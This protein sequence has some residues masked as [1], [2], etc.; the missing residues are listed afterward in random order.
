MQTH[1]C[2]PVRAPHRRRFAV[3]TTTVALLLPALLAASAAPVAAA[4]PRTDPSAPTT[5]TTAAPAPV[6]SRSA[7]GGP[8][9]AETGIVAAPGAP[10][11]PAVSAAAWVLADADTGEILA[12]K[13]PHAKY[14]PASTLKT[15]LAVTMAPRLDP[16]STYTADFEDTAQEGTRVGMVKDQTYKIDDLWYALLLRSGND[17]ATGI[18]KAGGGTLERGVAMMAAEAQRLQALDTTVVNPS[19][20]D[21]DGQFSSAYDLGLWGRALLARRDLRN[22]VK[23]IKH[24]FPGNKTKTA[25]KANSK[26]FQIYTENRLL[27]RGFP[28]AIGVKTGYTTKAQNTLIAAAERDGRTIIA[29][30]LSTPFGRITD[31]AGRLLEYGFANAGRVAPVGELVDPISSSVITDQDGGFVASPANQGPA[32]ARPASAAEE[33]DLVAADETTTLRWSA[34]AGGTLLGVLLLLAMVRTLA[35]RRRYARYGAYR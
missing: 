3:G 25:T 30:L 15:L 17:A 33:I 23:T 22:Y 7:I 26:S 1:T 28:G 5:S 16:N 4:D 2:L 9:M 29:T 11:L 13:D 19:G 31:D 20:L 10:T 34:V 27:L 35:T 21:E 18:A 6:P 24:T 8:R 32:V 14:R 12:A